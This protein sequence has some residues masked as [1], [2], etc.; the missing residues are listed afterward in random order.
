MSFSSNPGYFGGDANFLLTVGNLDARPAPAIG[1]EARQRR[2]FPVETPEDIVEQAVYLAVQRQ[3][4]ITFVIAN[5]LGVLFPLSRPQ[6]I[7]SRAL[8]FFLL[9]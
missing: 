8:I 2:Q 1:G 9:P 3:K 6:G 5:K 7:K 4:R